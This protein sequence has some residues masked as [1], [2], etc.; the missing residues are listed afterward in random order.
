MQLT[1]ERRLAHFCCEI[2]VNSGT[3]GYQLPN[4]QQGFPDRFSPTA[5]TFRIHNHA[6]YS[7][8]V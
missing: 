1:T 3:V 8:V 6:F 7:I 5:L 2:P 4:S